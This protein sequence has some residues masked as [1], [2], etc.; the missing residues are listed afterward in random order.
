[1]SKTIYCHNCHGEI[2]SK[3]AKKFCNQSC[4]AI[5]NNQNQ[6]PRSSESRKRTSESVKKA[7]KIKQITPKRLFGK[8]NPSYKHGKYIPKE[9]KCVNCYLEFKG[10]RK[11]C[12]NKCFRNYLS[13]KRIIFLKTNAGSFSW[14]NSR[15][16]PSY[17][18]L[19]FKKWLIK[20]GFTENIDF[21]INYHIVNNEIN[22]SYFLDFFFPKKNVNIECDGTHHEREQ[23]FIR[24]TIRDKFLSKQNITVYRISIRDY[25]RKNNRRIVLENIVKL[26]EPPVRFE[27]T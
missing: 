15:G 3:F 4:A 14:I 6:P 1:M 7:F 2:K 26:L 20:F 25:N 16:E 8:N 21:V 12:S 9:R 23:Q 11:T 24:D 13:K 27:L 19:N 22:T 18:E 17:F 5:F 10:I